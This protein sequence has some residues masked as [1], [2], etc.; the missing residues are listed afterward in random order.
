MHDNMERAVVLAERVVA[1]RAQL[2]A[3]ETELRALVTG[4]PSLPAPVVVR[5]ASIRRG[6]DD[7][8]PSVAA[9]VREALLGGEALTFGEM[10]QRV[11]GPPA[12]MAAR[13]ALRK[14]RKAGTVRFNGGRYAWKNGP[15]DQ[16]RPQG[17][18]GAPVRASG[19]PS[20]PG[21]RPA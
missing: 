17:L 4:T 10:V 16:G 12:A 5:P 3:A 14:L 21:P 19:A 6:D 18:G 11:G 9:Q 7:P 15:P 8:G 13:A 1:L 2:A 20:G